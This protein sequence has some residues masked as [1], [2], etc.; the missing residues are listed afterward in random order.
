MLKERGTYVLQFENG[1]KVTFV[2][3]TMAFIRFCEIS[4]DITYSQMM[5]VLTNE[6]SP[7]TIANLLISASGGDYT[8]KDAAEWIDELGGIAGKK[9]LE[10]INVAVAAIVDKGAKDDGKKKAVKK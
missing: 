3:N 1:D 4:G 9:L 2:F 8:I 6:L 10:V 7:K 5:N